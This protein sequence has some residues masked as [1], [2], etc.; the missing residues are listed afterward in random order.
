MRVLGLTKKDWKEGDSRRAEIKALVYI[1]CAA[2]FLVEIIV[3][4]ILSV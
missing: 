3:L 1:L 4:A 2:I